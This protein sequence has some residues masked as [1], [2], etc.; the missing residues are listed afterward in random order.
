MAGNW[1]GRL[2]VRLLH[3]E[4][5]GTPVYQEKIMLVYPDFSRGTVDEAFCLESA[6]QLSAEF[7]RATYGK[8]K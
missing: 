7:Y 5:T 6:I 4:E 8:Q 3:V 2:G 1:A